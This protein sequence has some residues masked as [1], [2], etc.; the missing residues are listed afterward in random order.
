MT[1]MHDFAKRAFLAGW[2]RFDR[3]QPV[4]EAR[5]EREFYEWWSVH[6]TPFHEPGLTDKITETAQ[7]ILRRQ[8]ETGD[9]TI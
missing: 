6:F 7:E 8:T 1:D 2:G 4:D 9:D 3:S 5:A